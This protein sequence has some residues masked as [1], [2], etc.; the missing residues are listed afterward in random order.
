MFNWQCPLKILW[1]CW[2]LVSLYLNKRYLNLLPACSILKTYFPQLCF[3][4][5]QI[6]IWITL[7]EI[8]Y[9]A[10]L[11]PSW[12]K[13]YCLSC[14][15]TSR[16]YFKLCKRWEYLFVIWKYIVK[17]LLSVYW[18][19]FHLTME[20]SCVCSQ[21][22]G[23]WWGSQ[24]S[25]AWLLWPSSNWAWIDKTSKDIDDNANKILVVGRNN[26]TLSNRLDIW[27]V[28]VEWE[29]C[30]FQHRRG[31]IN[32]WTNEQFNSFVKLCVHVQW[33]DRC[34]LL[35]KFKSE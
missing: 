1:N 32:N 17:A 28:S 31:Q 3:E 11:F 10:Q 7:Y 23:I 30:Q 20:E 27:C 19:L 24:N 14:C 35:V 6:Y 29:C 5:T 13:A 26:R 8:F 16:D 9:I 21:D 2:C 12:K 18:I 4:V 15:K 33:E 22:K 34:Q 25:Q